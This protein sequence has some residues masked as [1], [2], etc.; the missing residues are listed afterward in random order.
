[1]SK[2]ELIVYWLMSIPR[3]PIIILF[4]I[5]GLFTGL[6]CAI[7]PALCIEMQKRFYAKIN[8]RMEPIFMEKE[9]YNTRFMGWF[10]V[11]I[12]VI[13]LFLSISKVIIL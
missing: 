5:L 10:L 9:I 2:F 4:S 7:K 3:L 6:F 13:T 8:W 11:I 12:S 1:M